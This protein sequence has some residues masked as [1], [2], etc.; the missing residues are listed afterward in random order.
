MNPLKV[1][2]ALIV[3]HNTLLV[4]QRSSTMPLPGMWEFPG[5]K[6]EEGES[7]EECIVR[8]IKEELHLDLSIVRGLSPTL[9]HYPDK[10]IE[11]IPFIGSIPEDQSPLL[12][13]HSAL[14]W[15]T[16][17]ELHALPLAPADL[18][19]LETFE[20]IAAFLLLE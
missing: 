19:V 17:E 14:M 1:T 18:P 7:Y 16:I 9:W 3:R 13:E 2:C 8:E 10:S 4:V 20:E 12:R 11:L 6:V 5:G 15:A